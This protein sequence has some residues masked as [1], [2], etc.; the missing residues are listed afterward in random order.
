MGQVKKKV[1]KKETSKGALDRYEILIFL[2][3]A[4]TLSLEVLAS[5]VMTPYFGVSL[6]IWAGILSITLAFLALGYYLGGW[7]SQKYDGTGIESLFLGAPAASAFSIALAG[8][9]YPGIFPLLSGMNLILGSFIGAFLLLALPLTA[10]SA[11][12]PLLI[13][14]GRRDGGGGDGGAG[15]V[16]FISTVG[17]VVGVL[18]T[19][20]LFIPNMTNYRSLLLLGLTLSTTAVLLAFWSAALPKVR[21]RALYWSCGITASLCVAL[22]LGQKRY[23]QELADLYPKPFETEIR[24]EYGSIFGNVKVVE[25]RPFSGFGRPMLAYL[26]DG[27]V[28]NRTT[29]EGVSL[30]LYTHV[31]DRLA[32]AF[33]P[34]AEKTLVLGLGAG[35]IPRSFK[36]DGLSV[37]IVEINRDALR[38]AED[39]FG[40]DQQGLSVAFGDARTVV[41]EC[42][43]EYDIA[44]IDLFQGD[45]TPDYLMTTEFLQ[46]VRGCL[47]EGGALVMNVFFDQREEGP[48]RHLLAT[49]RSAFPWVFDYRGP[50]GGGF[51]VGTMTP[52]QP[53]IPPR[54]HSV[55]AELREMLAA[56]LSSG[57]AVTQHRLLEADP[58]RDDQNIFSVIFADA[59]LRLRR[60][61]VRLLPPQV[62][63]N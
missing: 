27:L 56:T 30:S 3:G 20:F 38:A 33:A 8:L 24:A 50:S 18:L 11:M 48:N 17:S 1:Q 42:L 26:Q 60:D 5:R 22:L 21:K 52:D 15:R 46:D 9:L 40:F 35:I 63:V 54:S 32:H 59:E 41:R 58:I 7:L 14:L 61:L 2:T 4:I 55:P 51:I 23:L 49:V 25:I 44:V 47:R 29:L 62:L 31:I 57:R 53:A 10:L 6:Y 19:A 12:N 39:H 34:Q 28:Q 13:A 16:F 43:S 37:D 36:E 45:G